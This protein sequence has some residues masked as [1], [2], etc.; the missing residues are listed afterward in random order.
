M[1]YVLVLLV[2]GACAADTIEREEVSATLT[3]TAIPRQAAWKYW[4]QGGDLGTAWRGTFDDATWPSGAGPLGYGESYLRTTVGYGPSASNKHITTYFRRAFAVDD[5]AAVTSITGELMFDDGAVIYLNGTRIAAASM[6]SGTVTAATRST[7]HEANNAYTTYDWTAH[8]ALLVAGTNVIAVEVHQADPTSSDLVFDLALTMETHAPPV[9][10]EELARGSSWSYWDLGG[11]PQAGWQTQGYGTGDWRRGN[12]P[13]GYGESYLATTVSYGPS[14]S[15]KYITTYFTTRITVDN[16]SAVT[17]MIGEVMWDDGFVVYLNGVEIHRA[18]MPAGTIAAG[19]LAAGH[20]ANGYETF[21]WTSKKHLLV[22]GRNNLAV[23]V[24]QQAASSSDLVFDLGLHLDGEEPPPPSAEA[25]IARASAWRYWDGASAPSTY[26]R[27]SELDFNDATWK[28]GAAPLGY[29]ESYIATTTSYGS[30]PSNKPITTYFRR[31]FTV[32]ELS[33][34]STM[35]GELLFDD[36]VIVYLNG[37]EIERQALPSNAGP[38]TPS[39]G[40]ETG[41]YE[42]FDWS[43]SIGYLEEG[44]NVIG[45]E[46]HQASPSSSDLSFDLSLEVSTPAVCA[47]D[48]CGPAAAPSMDAAF[49]GVWV[50]PAAVWTVGANGAIGRRTEAGGDWCWCERE[51]ETSWAGVWGAADDDLWIVGENGRVLHWDGVAMTPI[52]LGTTSYLT[53]V[54]G[55]SASDVWI[56]GTEGTVLHYDGVAWTSRPVPPDVV[57]QAIWGA[58][59]DDVWV[60]GTAYAPYPDPEQPWYD[61]SAGLIYRWQPATGTWL[62]EVRRTRYY[63]SAD[64]DGLGGSSATDVWAV[65]SDHPAGAA[66]SYSGAMRYD[67][68]AWRTVP[69]PDELQCRSFQSVEVGAPGAD[70][71][72]SGFAEGDSGLRYDDGVWSEAE[73]GTDGLMDFDHRGDRLWGVGSSYDNG[74]RHK[75]LEWDGASWIR[76]W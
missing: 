63:G 15:N 53:G 75:I 21:D 14:A 25:G 27:W 57:L 23:E 55:T 31:F 66:C 43:D 58:S 51:P 6:P 37:F 29:G 65:G 60:S 40:H 36:G 20:E 24:H 62:E 41:V 34:Q 30:N 64:F 26:N 7:G 69:I 61:G 33:S 76:S 54:W 1:R 52:E 59:A 48:G 22:P 16:P 42:P 12:G 71:W 56:I 68:T 4:D 70:V 32:E 46:V 73:R 28:T 49:S 10:L 9:E 72:V 19:T 45:V 18:A 2:L 67:G 35:T 38:T 39:T 13:L 8:R 50:G 3:T 74:S 11:T 47:I 44:L 5:P 17:S